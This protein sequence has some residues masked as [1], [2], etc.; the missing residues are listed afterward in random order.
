MQA[1]HAFHGRTLAA[2]DVARRSGVQVLLVRRHG[3]STP[4][5]PK[6]ADRIEVGDRLVVAGTV[7]DIERLHQLR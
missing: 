4:R 2:L 1:P 6:A 5:V 7:A 3:A